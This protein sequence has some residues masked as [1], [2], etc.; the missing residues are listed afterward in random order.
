MTEFRSDTCLNAHI[1]FLLR[2]ALRKAG[3]APR[4]E[5]IDDGGGPD[6]G[7][8]DDPGATATTRGADTNP[9]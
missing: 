6:V 9:G 8:G 7:N 1:E 2:D 5:P 4:H 3:R